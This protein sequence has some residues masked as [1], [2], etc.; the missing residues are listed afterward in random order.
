[1]EDV[2]RP[3]GV[4]EDVLGVL[5]DGLSRVDDGRVMGTVISILT[6]QRHESVTVLRGMLTI[7][8]VVPVRGTGKGEESV[9][10]VDV[11]SIQLFHGCDVRQPRVLP[12]VPGNGVSPDPSGELMGEE[13]GKDG[14]RNQN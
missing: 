7:E 11:T 6:G 5:L 12:W 2:V 14:V 10:L 3:F 1:M 13:W 8:T 9:L 4:L